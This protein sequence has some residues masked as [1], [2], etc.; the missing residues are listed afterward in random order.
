MEQGNSCKKVCYLLSQAIV[1]PL[2]A[3]T[4]FCGCSVCIICEN[5]VTLT[6]LKA[7]EELNTTESESDRRS[8]HGKPV[9]KWY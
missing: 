4:L 6:V 5:R 1:W 7:A 2:L 9:T 3:F 8:E